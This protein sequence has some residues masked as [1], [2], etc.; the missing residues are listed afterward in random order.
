MIKYVSIPILRV[1]FKKK[2]RSARYL[3]ND[4]NAMFLCFFCVFLGGFFFFS[5]LIFFIEAYVGGTHLNCLN[6]L[7]QFK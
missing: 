3:S 7:R 5:F 2:K 4:A 1:H 6:L